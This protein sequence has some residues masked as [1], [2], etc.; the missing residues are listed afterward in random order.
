MRL[1]DDF[2]D[3]DKKTGLPVIYAMLGG[4]AFVIVVILVVV[5]ANDTGI[6]RRRPAQVQAETDALELTAEDGNGEGIT[7]DDLDFWNMY[8]KDDKTVSDNAVIKDKSYEE[9]LKE[10]E[11]EEAEKAKEED[12]SE[13]GT[14]TKVV[15]PDGT[16]QWVMINAFI[17]KNPY[18]EEGFVYA[19]PMMKY[20]SDGKNVSFQGLML[21][22][23][24][25][26][27]D[28][29]LLKQD[30]INFV[31]LRIGYRGYESGVI[32]KDK[33]FED[34]LKAAVGAG[35]DVGV[36]FE[37]AAITEEEAAEESNFAC[38]VL[39]KIANGEN[40]DMVT[41]PE[42]T[43]AENT[44][45]PAETQESPIKVEGDTTQIDTS[46]DL[47]GIDPTT[48]TPQGNET[49]QQEAAPADVI[50]HNSDIIYPIAIKMGQPSNHSAR[51]D[52][53]P[54]TYVSRI[55]AAFLSKAKENGYKG[56]VWGDKYWLLRRM[57][58]TQLDLKTEIL[59]EQN[60]ELPD[61]PYLFQMWQYQ[62]DGKL[63]GIKKGARMMLSFVDYR[64]Q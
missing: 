9:R 40:T 63:S 31:M 57:D 22:E 1:S 12:L 41:T 3:N 36:Y 28:F 26:P 54:K 15:R 59:L 48:L 39:S 16:E 61:Y 4:M 43:T 45:K 49:G 13:G 37:S 42:S 35:I 19:D 23:S 56:I 47:T 18:K 58:L 62:S 27:V 24:D 33:M 51:T 14:K 60:E 64:Q 46:A 44:E 11:E 52:T 32:A 38:L 55:A 30:G 5:I 53:L 6:R 25:Q 20:F 8:A 21:D 29:A 50:S 17:E 10:M 7:A 34:Y 2:N